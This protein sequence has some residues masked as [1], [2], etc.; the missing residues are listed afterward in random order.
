MIGRIFKPTTPG[1]PGDP[2]FN[3]QRVITARMLNQPRTELEKFGRMRG[4][5]GVQVMDTPGGPQL[6]LS[7]PGMMYFELTS[8][9][10][11]ETGGYSWQELVRRTKG[12]DPDDPHNSSPWILTGYFGRNVAEDGFPY[13]PVFETNGD[14]ALQPTAEPLAKIYQA[15][16]SPTSGQWLFDGQF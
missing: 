10:N 4:N 8:R 2:S 3:Q 14:T 7:Y 16:R 9:I 12:I 1:Q 15:F 5:G 11:E 13:D 6:S